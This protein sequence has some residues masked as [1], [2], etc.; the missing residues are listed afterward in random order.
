MATNLELKLKVN[1]FEAIIQII[2]KQNG[3]FEKVLKQKDTYFQYDKGLLKLR[4][5]NGEFELVKYNRNEKAGERWSDYNLLFIKGE[6][7]EKY[8]SDLFKIEAIVKKTRNLYLYK[9]TR[10][11]LDE[12]KKLGNFLEL[13]TVVKN[14]SREE[15][16]KEFNEIVNFLNL[17]LKNEIRKSYRDLIIL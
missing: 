11:H 17:D 5:Q 1:N 14:I 8:L 15:A 10:I 7:I 12:V 4:E 16:I 9:N 6:N 3:K 13:E 2:L